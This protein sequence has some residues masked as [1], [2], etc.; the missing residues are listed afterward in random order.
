MPGE[1]EEK[2]AGLIDLLLR[3]E[4]K[5]LINT[6]T[7]YYFKNYNSLEDEAVKENI[8]RLAPD[9]FKNMAAAHVLYAQTEAI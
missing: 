6:A 2:E 8:K 5:T 9:L 4:T 1:I 3:A 7:I